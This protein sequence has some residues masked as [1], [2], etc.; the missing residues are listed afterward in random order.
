MYLGG[1]Q[2]AFFRMIPT[3]L[4]WRAKSHQEKA[5]RESIKK[6]EQLLRNESRGLKPVYENGQSPFG[7]ACDADSDAISSRFTHYTK[8]V[9]LYLRA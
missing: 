2:I 4:R 5:I 1:S 7:A 6:T 3:N 9:D 8:A